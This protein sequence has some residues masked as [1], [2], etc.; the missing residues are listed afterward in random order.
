MKEIWKDIPGYEGIY[1]VSTEGRIKSFHYTIPRIL[2]WKVNQ[3][4]YAWVE[5]RKSGEAK[6]L[7][8]H[9]IVATAFLDNPN[10]Y[11]VINHKDENPLNNNV[12]NLEWCSK[13]Y[14]VRYS[15]ALHP[16]RTLKKQRTRRNTKLRDK[17]I[18][19]FTIDGR[20]VREWPDSRTIFLETR[21]S[22]HSIS[23]CCRG[24]RHTA[25]G[26]KW[27]YAVHNSGKE[28]AL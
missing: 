12:D 28:A 14:N 10:N 5:L 7:L 9:R 27:Q 25:Y 22:D 2:T 20:F 6:Q 19:Q 3:K 17:A 21:M 13:S 16:E 26:Y 1:E 11:P 24:I 8:V 18:I 15:L 23:Q 4:G